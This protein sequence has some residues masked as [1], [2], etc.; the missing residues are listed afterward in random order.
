M[1][2]KLI[3]AAVVVATMASAAVAATPYRQIS[4]SGQG[5]VE[6]A[7]DMATISIGV[8]HQS[9]VAGDAMAQ[10]SDAVIAM[11]ERLEGMGV[12]PK[13]VQTQNLSL[14]PVWSNKPSDQGNIRQIT[15]YVASNSLS[16]QVRDL[17]RLG[18]IMDAV[19]TDGANDFNGLRFSIQDADPLM[20]QARAAAVKDAMDKAQQLSEAAG[21]SLGPVLKIDEGGRV[22]GPMPMMDAVRMSAE[23]MPIATG[24]V[25]VS[26]TVQMIFAIAE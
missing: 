20:A 14:N 9:D 4:V 18:T 15:G 2:N 16:V 12:L 11:L 1:R 5:S 23:A 19:I 21:V 10:T 26:A 6:A 24:E 17:S 8:T 13:D 25:S 3:A 7:P 22:S